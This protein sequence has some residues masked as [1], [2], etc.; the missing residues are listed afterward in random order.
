M[1]IHKILYGESPSYL[2]NSVTLK[3]SKYSLR[4]ENILE[5]SR[6]KSTKYGINIFRCIAA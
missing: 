1:E 6:L 5:V 3:D 2:R 4:Y